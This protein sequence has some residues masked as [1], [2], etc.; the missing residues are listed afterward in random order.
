[1]WMNEYRHGAP[2]GVASNPN[3]RGL[4]ALI[5]NDAWFWGAAAVLFSIVAILKG[6]RL[7]SLWAATQANLDYHQGFIKRGLF[8]QLARSSGA[9]IAHYE[10][11]VLLSG[12]LLLTLLALLAWWVSRSG[13]PRLGQGVV[14]AVF[15]ASYILTYLAQL[16]GYLEIPLAVLALAAVSS[17]TLHRR[18]IGVF[19]SGALGVLI[20]ESY[21]LTFLPMTLLPALLAAF[22]GQRSRLRALMP[23]AAVVAAIAVVALIVAL[24]APMTPQRVSDLQVAMTATVDFPTRGD[25]FPILTRSA[26]DNV[27]IMMKTMSNGLWWLA[28]CNAFITFV[29]T[30]A[31]FLWIALDIVDTGHAEGERFAVKTLVVFASLCPLAMQ[32]VGWDIYRW[33]ALAAFSSFVSMTIV[34]SHYGGAAGSVRSPALRNVG[35]LL[36]AINMATGTGLFDGYRVDT[37]PFVDLWK[38]AIHWAVSGGHFTQP[39]N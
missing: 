10:V 11:F 25:F 32:L 3:S 16:I 15:G 19:L 31:F 27:L 23:V 12:A 26:A 9:H 13:A 38:S 7:P 37:F 5:A 36:I 6:L 33:Y 28:Q 14:V 2:G 18:L 34:C 39:A 22:S 29:P 17:S 24:G 35:M 21:V 4:A 20:H 30:I 1:M 8:G